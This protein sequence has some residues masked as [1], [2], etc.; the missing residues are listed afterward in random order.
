MKTKLYFIV[1]FFFVGIGIVQA[2]IRGQIQYT[3][4]IVKTNNVDGFDKIVSNELTT[5]EPG[6]PELPVLLKSYLIP[7]DAD[8]VSINI[9][10]VNKQKVEGQYNIYPAQPPIPTDAMKSISFIEPNLEIYRSETPFPNKMAEI[11]SD[12]FYLGYRIVT[13]RL[14]PFEYLPARKELYACNMNF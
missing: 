7:V 9:K 12:E 13:V 1:I 14:Y 5:A 3:N 10:N 6:S 11:I 4:E 2:Q 8:G